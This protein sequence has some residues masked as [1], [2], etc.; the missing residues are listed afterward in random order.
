MWA[1]GWMWLMR[2]FI[3]DEVERQE[4]EQANGCLRYTREELTSLVLEAGF[5]HLEFEQT[6]SGHLLVVA[7]KAE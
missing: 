3:V 4:D 6:E 7:A 2:A 5:R 1:S